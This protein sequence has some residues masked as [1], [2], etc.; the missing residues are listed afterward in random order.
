MAAGKDPME[1]IH[2]RRRDE[3]GS[4]EKVRQRRFDGEGLTKKVRDREGLLKKF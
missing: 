2:R 4:L 3:E 1:K